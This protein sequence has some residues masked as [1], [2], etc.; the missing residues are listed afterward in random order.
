[1]T[2]GVAWTRI[3][4][5]RS[6]RRRRSDTCDTDLTEASMLEHCQQ[7]LPLAKMPKRIFIVPDLPKCVRSK[8]LHD[9]LRD[10]WAARQ[11]LSA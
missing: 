3:V 7:H 1:M 11:K 2:P 8:V 5:L 10:D 4:E 9:K 6:G